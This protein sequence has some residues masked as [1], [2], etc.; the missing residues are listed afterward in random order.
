VQLQLVLADGRALL[1]SRSE[2]TWQ[3]EAIYD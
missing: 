2:G 3:L 1:V